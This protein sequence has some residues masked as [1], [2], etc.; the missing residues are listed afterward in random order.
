MQLL[1]DFDPNMI[2][3]S[4]G[5]TIM[6]EESKVDYN[7]KDEKGQVVSKATAEHMAKY[8]VRCNACSKNFCA[9]CKQEPY[10]LGR[11]CEEAANFKAALKCRFCW[12]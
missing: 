1:V 4:C 10:H 12:E 3:C 2:N 8:R 6:L 5:A 11:S 7:A 9:N